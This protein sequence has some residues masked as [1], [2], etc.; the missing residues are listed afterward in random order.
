MKVKTT[1]TEALWSNDIC[2]RHNTIITDINLKM[3]NDTKCD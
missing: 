2:E 3:R 1:A